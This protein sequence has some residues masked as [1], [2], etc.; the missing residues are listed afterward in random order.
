[1]SHRAW[2]RVSKQLLQTCQ[3][4]VISLGGGDIMLQTAHDNVRR[5]ICTA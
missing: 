4:H 3:A 1:M 2:Q 5:K